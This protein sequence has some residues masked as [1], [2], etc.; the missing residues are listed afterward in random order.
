MSLLDVTVRHANQ[1]HSSSLVISTLTC[2]L[3]LATASDQGG[4]FDSEDARP[5]WWHDDKA[6]VL[7][8]KVE[9]L[10]QG[11]LPKV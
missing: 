1:S 10:L 5:K 3:G 8:D 11:M 7:S 9:N 4:P 2:L 6:S